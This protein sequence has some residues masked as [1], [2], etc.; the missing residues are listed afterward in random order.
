MTIDNI[1]S[2]EVVTADGRHI[3]A[4][5][6]ENADLLWAFHGGGGNFGVVTSFEFALHDL[7]PE[8]YALDVA[9][10]IQDA[11][12]VLTRWRD[13]IAD[14]P[15]AL[16]TDAMLWSL[17][18]IPEVPAHF[19]KQ[20]YVGI[21]GMYVGDPADGERVTRPL[22]ELSTPLLDASGTMAYL[23]L[24]RSMDAFFPAGLRYYW[25]ALYLDDLADDAID[26]IVA[27][28]VENAVGRHA[29]LHAPSAARW[30]ACRPARPR[31]ATAARSSCSA[32]TRAGS[33]TRD[34]DA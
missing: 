24:Q 15:D 14:T 12:R 26:V 17:P 7:G 29:R 27:R 10:P 8:V 23:D 18:V 2:A 16:T 3:R 33:T 13:A 5:G 21:T 22:R 19:R 20:P 34:D 30:A 4:A 31:S 32:S 1:V 25:K 11:R 28:A 9:Y 6:D